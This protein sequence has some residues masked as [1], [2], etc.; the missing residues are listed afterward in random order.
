[1]KK[2]LHLALA[3]YCAQVNEIDELLK[4]QNE[5]C[6]LRNNY[7]AMG[8]RVRI[9]CMDV[10]KFLIDV[11]KKVLPPYNTIGLENKIHSNI[12]EF[13]MLEDL[14]IFIYINSDNCNMSF[15]DFCRMYL[16]EKKLEY[17][18]SLSLLPF[19][20]I[21]SA[22]DLFYHPQFIQ[23]Y[24]KL[25]DDVLFLGEKFNYVN[26]NIKFLLLFRLIHFCNAEL[27]LLYEVIHL[28]KRGLINDILANSILF[29]NNQMPFVEHI[30]YTISIKK[31]S[32]LIH[33]KNSGENKE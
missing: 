32:K 24:K 11:I 14:L 1:M 9:P 8:N 30:S 19:D 18:N 29:L 4:F 10:G 15:F 13:I 27:K 6:Q 17:I 16:Y 23:A 26:P 20:A 25:H 22:N 28:E 2:L 21:K 33:C 31:L 5:L 7:Y 12:M 3:C